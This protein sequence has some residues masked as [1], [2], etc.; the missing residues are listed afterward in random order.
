MPFVKKWGFTLT[1]RKD[2]SIIPCDKHHISFHELLKSEDSVLAVNINP[3]DAAVLQY[4][5][6]TTG[7]P[8]AAVLTHA[9]LYA[10]TF[11]TGL[12]F[13]GLKYGEEIIIGA[14][15]L[16][17]V[18]SMTI[19]MN[20]SVHTGSTMLLYPKFD[21]KNILADIDRKRPTLIPGVPTMFAAINNYKQLS[22]YNLTSIKM[23][24]SGGG[25][26]PQEVKAGFEKLTGA[27]LIE[28][29][30]LSESSPVVSGNP[31]FGINKTGSIGIPFPRTIIQIRDAE[32][33]DK[34]M[35]VGEIG[36]ICIS[37]PQIM[38]G[39]L[40]NAEETKKVIRNGFLHTGDLGTMD[41][42]GY[43]YVVDRIKEMIIS[44]GYNIYPR[45]LE[46]ILYQHPE[47]LEAAV[48]GVDHP[49]RVQ[50]PKA[51]IVRK[52]GSTVTEAEIKEFM[53]GKISAYALPHKIEFR[54]SLPK[55]IIGKILKKKLVEEEKSKM[56]KI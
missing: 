27:K 43:F 8:K 53:R 12:W 44:G 31:L 54:D 51:F 37:G 35:D 18:F 20:L 30:G 29:Y 47:I 41:S 16:F 32:N 13:T 55:S 7:V 23:G 1:R 48:I 21:M 3:E 4:T 39:Y 52:P 5:G 9:N 15:P 40:N 25:P 33:P 45:N 36:E 22:K 2:I 24:I 50:E 46:E 26:L 6:G 38:K 28:G 42:D 56:N 19:V 10:N 11:Q 14:L 34:I 49:E 17:H